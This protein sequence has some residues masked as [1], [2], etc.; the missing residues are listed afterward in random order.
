[1]GGRPRKRSR[2][3]TDRPGERLG[4]RPA[5]LVRRSGKQAD[6][7]HGTL[8][9]LYRDYLASGGL[10]SMRASSCHGRPTRPTKPR[11]PR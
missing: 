2:D 1:M 6:Q 9:V 10:D 7:L 4:V 3:H 8:R 5:R 11:R